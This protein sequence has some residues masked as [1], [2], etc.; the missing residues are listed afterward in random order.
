MNDDV[1]ISREVSPRVIAAVRALNDEALPV[2]YTAQ[3]YAS[4]LDAS[5]ASLIVASA[6]RANDLLAAITARFEYDDDASDAG[7][8]GNSNEFDDDDDDNDDWW[9]WLRW[10]L[11]PRSAAAARS[12]NAPHRL[13]LMTLA[14]RTDARRC[15]LASRLVQTA[16]EWA[17]A[18]NVRCRAVSLHVKA[19]NRPALAFYARLGFRQHGPV[20]PNHY[21]IAQVPYD[22]LCLRMPLAR[23]AAVIALDLHDDAALGRRR[24]QRR[25]R[26]AQSVAI[27]LLHVIDHSAP[28]FTSHSLSF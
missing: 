27:A 9:W 6:W 25:R 3:Y 22:G 13:Y 28:C 14:V 21:R 12:P 11:P 10:L 5:P 1:V 19:S 15:G 2:R 26:A 20:L 7:G 24:R 8:N 18:T 23:D 16:L 17:R 4:L